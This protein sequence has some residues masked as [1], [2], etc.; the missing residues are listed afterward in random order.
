MLACHTIT[1]PIMYP[2]TGR[3]LPI[4]AQTREALTA[5]APKANNNNPNPPESAFSLLRANMGT[6]VV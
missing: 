5:P 6:S 2:P 3:P 4:I 1:D